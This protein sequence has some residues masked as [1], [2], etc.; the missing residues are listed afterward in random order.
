[1]CKSLWQ[2][3]LPYFGMYS[4][5]YEWAN[6]ISAYKCNADFVAPEDGRTQDDLEFQQGIRS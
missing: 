2:K 5:E 4:F 1:M 6:L 3:A